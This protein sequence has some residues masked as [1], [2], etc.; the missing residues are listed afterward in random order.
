M[1]VLAIVIAFCLGIS[2][3]CSLLGN[4]NQSGNSLPSEENYRNEPAKFTDDM[5]ERLM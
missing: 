4:R 5:T 3:A 2:F 1:M